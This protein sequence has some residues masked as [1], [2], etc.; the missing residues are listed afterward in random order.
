MSPAQAGRFFTSEPPGE[1]TVYQ[2]RA[3]LSAFRQQTCGLFLQV[4]DLRTVYPDLETQ[5]GF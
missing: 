3:Q 5:P 1:P 2:V 4:R